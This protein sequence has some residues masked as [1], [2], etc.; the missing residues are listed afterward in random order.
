MDNQDQRDFL[1]QL[2]EVTAESEGDRQIIYP[3]LL[4]HVDWLEESFVQIVREE[5]KT[6][7]TTAEDEE[8]AYWAGDTVLELCLLIEDFLEGDRLWNLEIAIAGLESLRVLIKRQTYPEEWGRIQNHL[9]LLYL[10]RLD[11]DIGENVEIAIAYLKSALRVH[12]RQDYPLDWAITQNN[13]GWAFSERILGDPLENLDQSIFHYQAALEIGYSPEESDFWKDVNLKLGRAYL[14]RFEQ[15]LNSKLSPDCDLAIQRFKSGLDI[16]DLE[17]KTQEQAILRYQLGL[18]YSN[19]ETGD[20]QENIKCAIHYFESALE[21]LTLEENPVDWILSHVYLGTHYSNLEPPNAP[22]NL[23]KIISI[24]QRVI[25]VIE[26]EYDLEI[27]G[28]IHRLV[29][30]AYTSRSEGDRSHNLEQIILYYQ[31]I[32]QTLPQTDF[33]EEWAITQNDLGMVYRER[34]TGDRLENLYL[35]KFHLEQSLLVYSFEEYPAEWTQGLNNLGLVY[36]EISQLDNPE[37]LDQAITLYQTALEKNPSEIGTD[38]WC[39]LY[40]NLGLAYFSKSQIDQLDTQSLNQAIECYNLALEFCNVD[41]NLELWGFLQNNLAITHIATPVGTPTEDLEN[42]IQILEDTLASLPNDSLTDRELRSSLEAN[43]GLAYYKRQIGNRSQNIENSIEYL[44]QALSGYSRISRPLEWARTLQNLALAYCERKQGSQLENIELAITSY[45]AALQLY[46]LEKTPQAWALTC[47]NL[48]LAYWC[49]MQGDEVENTENA[50]HCYERA[51]QAIDRQTQP[52]TWAM[53]HLNLAVIYS[54]RWEGG[55]AENIQRSLDYAQ[56]ALEIFTRNEFPREWATLQQIHGGIYYNSHDESE[57]Q[58][59]AIQYYQAALGVFTE[60][61]YSDDWASLQNFLG[62]IYRKRI[63]GDRDENLQQALEYCQ[64]ALRIHTYADFPNSWADIQDNLGWLYRDLEQ[65]DQAIACFQSALEFRNLTHAPRSCLY[66]AK[67]LGKTLTEAQRWTDA[68]AAYK[69]AIE[70]L[71]KI[72]TW[73]STDERRQEILKDGIKIYDDM[74]EACLITGQFD[75]AFAYVERARCR[76]LVD[77][78]VSNDLDQGAKIPSEV[79]QYL[80]EFESIQQQIDR[81]RHHYSQRN[82]PQQLVGMLGNASFV[83]ENSRGDRASLQAY[84][85]TIASLEAQKQQIWQQLRRLD[86]VLAGEIQ[87][88]PPDFKTI[89]EL[90]DSTM[91][92]ISFYTTKD[93]TYIFI[94]KQNHIT[95]HTCFGQGQETLQNWIE[96]VWLQPYIEQKA[97]WKASLSEVLTEL[98]TRLELKNWIDQHLA[99]IAELILIPYRYLHQIPFAALPISDEQYLSDQFLIRYVPSCQILEF[100]AKRPAVEFMNCGIVEDATEDLPCAT[101][102]G[103]QIAQLY[104]IPEHQRL[105]GRSQATVSNYRQL[106]TQ[107]QT[108][109]SSHHAQ[110]RLDNP[111]ESHL[112]LA[113]GSITL[114]QLMSPGWRL[115]N[116]ADV[117]LSCCETGLGVTELTDDIFTLSS[118]FL[119]AGARSV[120]S[121]LWTV[122]DL[123]T[124]LFSIFYHQYRYHGYSRPDAL[125]QAQI[126]LRTLTGEV[127]ASQYKAHLTEILDQKFAEVET[128]RQRVESQLSQCPPGTRESEEWEQEERRYA[129][130]ATAIYEATECLEALCYQAFPFSHPYYWAAFTSSGLR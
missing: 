117:F 98:A 109:V 118:G 61:E 32:V 33:P 14:A 24:G 99:G 110:S 6:L 46:S 36:S 77:L 75:L 37:Y 21:G 95:C 115:P 12:T 81:E 3:L 102:E 25:P 119:C 27:W 91:A 71:E 18:A 34:L 23:E 28:L 73:G 120:V 103:S 114:G 80:R 87:V 78:M 26:P 66:S 39:T 13:L 44:Q 38:L 76:G 74:V 2:L 57:N 65:I 123:A 9:G 41:D 40:S 17:V 127:L 19:R 105:K 64:A 55:Q 90:I 101:F 128:Q 52:L 1:F 8:T 116:L 62:S 92:I 60:Q 84:N 126:R 67:A 89:G 69:L 53:I 108:I 70:A 54:Y 88:S 104:Q 100:C 83:L 31:T 85:E 29:A 106:I 56:L 121:T 35:S 124:A 59:I 107:V 112:Q 20:S 4:S 79:K 93:H 11:G 7:L 72:R 49:R 10:D 94:L 113:D 51:L 96:Q 42:A 111:L 22:D 129:Q 58:E 47:N 86:P 16:C 45:E 122:D 43:L 63:Q 68:I 82:Q 30:N 5:V 97:Q 50:I 125:R 15:S 130:L 48:G